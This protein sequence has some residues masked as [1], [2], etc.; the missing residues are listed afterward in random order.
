MTFPYADSLPY[1]I[2]TAGASF[3]K[4]C[5]LFCHFIQQIHN[6]SNFFFFFVPFLKCIAYN[7]CL[8]A[9]VPLL[10]LLFLKLLEWPTIDWRYPCNN[11]H[12]LPCFNK[13]SNCPLAVFSK[14]ATFF[15]ISFHF[16]Y[17]PYMNN[18]YV[19]S[20]ETAS[21]PASFTASIIAF[22]SIGPLTSI[23][24]HFLSKSTVACTPVK[25]I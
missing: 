5:C 13:P 10:C 25:S 15:F 2:K 7:N 20:T 6:L 14:R 8:N 12:L 21:N 16:S 3:L 17:L 23:T 24:A 22:S 19:Y 1:S 18:D 4:P 9:P 11:G